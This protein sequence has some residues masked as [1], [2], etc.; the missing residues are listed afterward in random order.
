[1]IIN[2]L[3]LKNI[4][5]YADEKISFPEGSVMLSGDIGSGKSTILLAIEFALF[6]LLRGEVEGAALLRHG[7]S[8]ASVVLDFSIEGKQVRVCRTLKKNSAG[9]AQSAGYIEIG[10][11]RTEYTAVELKARILEL[12]GYPKSLL[13]KSKS[14][15]YRYTVY[16]PQEEMKR[17]LFED[18]PARLDTLRKVFQVD[19]YKTARENGAVII[20]SIKEQKKLFEAL[21]CNL[22]EKLEEKKTAEEKTKGFEGL[23]EIVSGQIKR[24]SKESD[25]QRELIKSL[26][27]KKEQGTEIIRQLS[28]A[29]NSLAEKSSLLAKQEKE[30]AEANE[31]LKGIK[32]ET[33]DYEQKSMLLAEKTSGLKNAVERLEKSAARKGEVKAA[34]EGFEKELQ[35]I[36]SEIASGEAFIKE[37]EQIKAKVGELEKC[38]LCMQPVT[39]EHKARIAAAED[40]KAAELKKK[41]ERMSAEKNVGEKRMELLK[42]SLEQ[43][44]RDELLATEAKS[45][46]ERCGKASQLQVVLTDLKKELPEIRE[47]QKRVEKLESSKMLIAEKESAAESLNKKCAELRKEIEELSRRK[48]ELEKKAKGFES[49]KAE[50]DSARKVLEG[51]LNEEKEL[52]AKRAKVEAELKAGREKT[53][54]LEK[55]VAEKEEAKKKLAKLSEL[56]QWIEEAFLNV[57]SVMEKQVML[58]IHGEFSSFFQ[59]WFKVLLEDEAINSRLDDSFSPVVE[60]NGY[61]TG[62][63]NLSGGEKTS[64]AL[65]YRLALNKVIN[66]LVTTI[67]TK[68]LLILDEPTDGFS[69]E[70]LDRVRDV[71]EQLS[72]Q[73]LIIVSHETKIESF[74][75]SVIRVSKEEGVSRAA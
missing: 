35:K 36:N 50:Y 37:A 42:E 47:L 34:I 67:K 69:T 73:Q 11:T 46:L 8:S 25:E 72:V 48:V 12:L 9:I 19:K 5:S 58:K 51:M 64:C 54:S 10:G 63:H 3:E 43:V 44:M 71:I 53:A 24:I 33:G 31:K 65:A 68:N 61:E 52:A 59:Q 23:L 55:E 40:E 32:K 21:A 45:V 2:S 1:M 39:D 66:D 56:H 26:E 4:R 28:I 6:G 62:I 75:Q 29:E 18:A 20:R 41:V 13:T 70:Q 17:I 16:T 7:K 74:V 38:P 49:A 27:G 57:V 22:S 15:I 30:I 60:Q 14:L